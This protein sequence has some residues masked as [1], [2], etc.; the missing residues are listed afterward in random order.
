MT[1]STA[2]IPITEIGMPNDTMRFLTSGTAYVFNGAIFEGVN[3][4]VKQSRVMNHLTQVR[5][6]LSDMFLLRSTRRI[7]FPIGSNGSIAV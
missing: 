2:Y 6:L 7:L 1:S 5:F 4:V 3:R